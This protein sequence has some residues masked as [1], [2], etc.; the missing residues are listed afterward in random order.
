M[1]VCVCAD[2]ESS[3][4][5]LRLRQQFETGEVAVVTVAAAVAVAAKAT[6]KQLA[7][8][9][10]AFVNAQAPE[11][12]SSTSNADSSVE[13]QRQWRPWQRVCVWCR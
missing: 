10:V 4:P 11:L 6:V 13:S 7:S 3:R 1:F 9:P 8:V 2:E 12:L 5:V